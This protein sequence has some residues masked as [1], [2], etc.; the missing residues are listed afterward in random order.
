MTKAKKTPTKKV[1]MKRTPIRRI[2]K[3]GKANLEANRR[4]KKILPKEYCEVQLD[5][6]MNNWPLTWAHRHKRSWYK[7]DPDLLADLNQVVVA[8]QPCHDKIEHDKE[9]TEKVFSKLRE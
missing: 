8:C 7:G 3:V 2:G 9:L 5:G 1:T 6:C 4:L